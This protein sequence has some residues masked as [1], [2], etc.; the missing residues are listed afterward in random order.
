VNPEIKKILFA[1]DLHET[2]RHVFSYAAIEATRHGASMVLLHVME[3]TPENVEAKVED[4]FGRERWREI[5]A[6]KVRSAREI[7]IG[8]RTAFDMIR[9]ALADFCADVKGDDPRCSFDAQE[10]LVVQ[11]E[12]AEEILKTAADKACDLIIMG[13]HKGVFG[14]NA[15]SSVI[16][17]VLNG[18]KVPVLIVPPPKA[19]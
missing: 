4:M 11:G 1:S 6:S 13:A 7:L 9:G 16:K 18:T 14:K 8:K 10:I 17:A 12:V 2:A 15:I 5:Q 19:R 3:D